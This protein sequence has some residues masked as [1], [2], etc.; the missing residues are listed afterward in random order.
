MLQGEVFIRELCAIDRLAASAIACSEVSTLAHELQH[1]G[2][3][4][5]RHGQKECWHAPILTEW[6]KIIT[7]KPFAEENKSKLLPSLTFSLYIAQVPLMTCRRYVPKH[8]S[9]APH[10]IPVES[11]GGK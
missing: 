5:T 6:Q 4:N 10:N 3:N 9:H 2:T 1:D 7:A 8:R 11:L